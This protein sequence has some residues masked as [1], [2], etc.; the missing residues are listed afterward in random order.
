MSNIS[1]TDI[2]PS[3]SSLFADVESY[4]NDLSE[5]DIND[6]LGAGRVTIAWTLIDI[7]W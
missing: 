2:N 1:I 5:Q 7:Q 3:G 4:L 6:I